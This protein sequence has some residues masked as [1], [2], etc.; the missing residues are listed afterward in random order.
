MK[1]ADCFLRD[2]NFG[3]L[4]VTLTIIVGGI[5]KNGWGLID[6]GTLKSGVSHNWFD[7]LSRLIERFLHVDGDGIICGWQP[8]YSVSLTLGEPLQLYIARDIRKNSLWAKM[9]P[10]M[11]FFFF[12]KIFDI[13]FCLKCT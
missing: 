4:K 7:E 9:T 3:K 11:F 10:R 6:H 5:V 12:L 2:K 8:I 1:W 13:E